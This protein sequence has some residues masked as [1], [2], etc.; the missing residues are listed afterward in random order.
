MTEAKV[1]AAHEGATVHLAGYGPATA[2]KPAIVPEKV[3]QELAG[4]RPP[5]P[6]CDAVR[7]EFALAPGVYAAPE[8]VAAVGG[9]GLVLEPTPEGRPI[10]TAEPEPAD[11]VFP[12]DAVALPEPEAAPEPP[13]R[14]ARGRRFKNRPADEPV[15]TAAPDA[16]PPAESEE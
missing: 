5:M 16:A 2:T 4:L 8:L 12:A 14:L 6:A 7:V 13:P 11:F 9:L 3:G 10:V 1:Y 15:D